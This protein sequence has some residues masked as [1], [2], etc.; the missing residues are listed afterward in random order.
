MIAHRLSY[1]DCIATQRCMK[2]WFYM[3]KLIPAVCMGIKGGGVWIQISR[4][5]DLVTNHNILAHFG[6]YLWT[7]RNA[8]AST[9]I[10]P[11]MII[12]QKVI[13]CRDMWICKFVRVHGKGNNLLHIV[14]IN[15][16][17]IFLGVTLVVYFLAWLNCCLAD[18]ILVEY[19]LAWL[20]CWWLFLGVTWFLLNI[21]WRD[22]I[23]VEYFLAWLNSCCIFLGVT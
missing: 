13:D 22:L 19:F 21:S 9:Y 16:C 8:N 1:F 12:F 11:H 15:S 4:I 23:L 3:N 18:L 10:F 17:W 5:V 20:N 14:K 2:W 7:H 6:K